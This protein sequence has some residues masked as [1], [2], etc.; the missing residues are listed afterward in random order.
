MVLT[1]VDVME[2]RRQLPLRE[3][4]WFQLNT[5]GDMIIPTTRMETEIIQGVQGVC[6]QD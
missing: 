5:E 2:S 3:I 4:Q 6:F 1:D